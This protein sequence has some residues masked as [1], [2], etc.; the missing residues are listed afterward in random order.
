MSVFRVIL[1]MD[2]A[3]DDAERFERTWMHAASSFCDV[4]GVVSQTLAS[5]PNQPGKFTITSDW[6][7]DASFRAF[8]TSPEQD[9]ATAELRRLR[10]SLFVRTQVV[11]GIVTRKA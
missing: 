5:E 8:E 2:V 10:R 1:E 9:A 4:P 6:E 3:E 7:D 11:H